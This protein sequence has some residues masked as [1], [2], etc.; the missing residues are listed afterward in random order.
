MNNIEIF[1]L[2]IFWL[3]LFFY[4]D[5]KRLSITLANINVV[6]DFSKYKKKIK[7]KKFFLIFLL[8]VLLFG[9]SS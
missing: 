3:L 7:N 6:I 1:F 8:V 9:F 4:E 2:L 5:V